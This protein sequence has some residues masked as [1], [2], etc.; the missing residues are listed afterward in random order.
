VAFL[1]VVDDLLGMLSTIELDDDL[2]LEA[3]EVGDEAADHGLPLASKCRHVFATG[4]A[5]VA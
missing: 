1:T 3:G 2:L 4:T 5:I